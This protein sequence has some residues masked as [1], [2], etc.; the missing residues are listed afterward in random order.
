MCIDIREKG[1]ER[2]RERNVNVREE[3]WSAASG[4]HPDGDWTWNLGICPHQELNLSLFG[5]SDDA[6][7][8]W[9]TL[10]FLFYAS[11]YSVFKKMFILSTQRVDNIFLLFKGMQG[12]GNLICWSY[13]I[14]SRGWKV[15][16]VNIWVIF[17]F[18]VYLISF[19][20]NIFDL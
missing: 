13:V 9:V 5:L 6:P 1:R 19:Y 11:E 8:N 17:P 10:C 12:T 7:T 4:K 3:H 16:K 15:Q 14:P 18:C 20:R 2:E